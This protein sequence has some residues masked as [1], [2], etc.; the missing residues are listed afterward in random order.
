MER[1]LITGITR[2]AKESIFSDLNNLQVVSCTKN[3]YTDCFGFTEQEVFAAM[4]EYGLADKQ[5]VKYWYDGFNF[6]KTKGIYN[7]WSIINYLNDQEFV[8]YW[9][10]SSSNKLISDLIIKSDEDVKY[11]TSKLLQ[12]D[13][14][15]TRNSLHAT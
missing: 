9:V 15:I 12:G 7:P 10:N 3:L 13:S 5:K 6:G 14:I 4:D 11:E 2:V 1:G 8:T